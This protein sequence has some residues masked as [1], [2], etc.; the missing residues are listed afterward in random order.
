M[1]P[2][3]ENNPSTINLWV[4]FPFYNVTIIYRSHTD[5]PLSRT[6]LKSSGLKLILPSK[7][8][9]IFMYTRGV[10]PSN[11]L[12]GSSEVFG[13][14]VRHHDCCPMAVLGF[15]D[16]LPEVDGLHVF[17]G[18]DALR[19]ACGVTCTSLHQPPGSVCVNWPLVLQSEEHN[20]R[21]RRWQFKSRFVHYFTVT[22][23][24]ETTLIL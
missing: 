1:L 7:D 16:I 24:P 22:H 21:S 8:T 15:A 14:D 23:K 2:L 4:L 19:N 13:D 11:H 3:E 12:P 20:L 9:P 6:N 17:N 18:Q 10:L 5:F